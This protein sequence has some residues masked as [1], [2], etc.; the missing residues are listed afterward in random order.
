MWTAT[1][2]SKRA[3]RRL[4]IAIAASSEKLLHAGATYAS[5]PVIRTRVRSAEACGHAKSATPNIETAHHVRVP[6][7]AVRPGTF[8]GIYG[9]QDRLRAMIAGLRG[10]RVGRK[11]AARQ[12]RRGYALAVLEAGGHEAAELACDGAVDAVLDGALRGGFGGSA[13]GWLTLLRCVS[14]HTHGITARLARVALP[15]FDPPRIAVPQSVRTDLREA[16]GCRTAPDRPIRPPEGY[17]SGENPPGGG[18]PRC[19]SG[20]SREAS[21]AAGRCS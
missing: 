6:V 20:V 15:P 17:G 5:R 9:P 13:E 12:E 19:L 1:A 8:R 2:D 14:Q 3:L 7:T 11:V 10:V 21:T 4:F 16:Y 18:S